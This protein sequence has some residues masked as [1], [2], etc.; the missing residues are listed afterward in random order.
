[1]QSL[2][3]EAKKAEEDP[4][5]VPQHHLTPAQMTLLIAYLTCVFAWLAHLLTDVAE[6]D[7]F[8]RRK[9]TTSDILT[10]CL[11][12]CGN[13]SETKDDLPE[14]DTSLHQ[15]RL[16]EEVVSSQINHLK[17]DIK[18]RHDQT[19]TAEDNEGSKKSR[20][21]SVTGKHVAERQ[22]PP[23]AVTLNKFMSSGTLFGLILIYFF[24]CDYAKI[25][26]QGERSYSRDTFL[27]LVF[28]FFLA[29]CAFTLKSNPDKILN[30]DQTEEWKGWM[31]VM[32]VWYH[33]FMAKE[34]YNWIRIYI[35]C[36]VWMTG[37][38]NFSFFWVRND[39]S[40]LRL[41]KMMFR[42]NFLVTFVALTT[43]NEYMLYYICAMHTYWFLS[44][45]IFMRT[46]NSWNRSSSLMAVKFLVY[47]ICNAVIFDIPGVTYYVFRPFTFILGFHDRSEDILHEWTFRAGLDHWACFF[48]MLCAYN[49]PHFEAFM[50]Y[51]DSKSMNEKDKAIKITLR[52][53]LIIG[54][55]L[56]G[57]LWYSVFMWRDKISYNMTH[58][59][60]SMIPIA[61]FIVLR[62]VHPVL[63][64]YH[65]NM[66]AWLG[67]ITLETYLSQLHIY[68]LA[69]ARTLLVFL[70]GY[71]LLNFALATITYLFVSHTL[72]T[73]TNDF[74]N[75]LI[76]NDN[77]KLL[78]NLMY[79]VI[80]FSVS[81]L[82]AYC[83]SASYT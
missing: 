38:G 58:P 24:L 68:L 64:S 3:S 49:Y 13:K 22:P 9:T 66:F 69:N 57:V 12:E 74:S 48:G 2:L 60:S 42:L 51:L 8:W 18:H 54:C 62:N 47:A 11:V 83:T 26:P 40:L 65:V 35:A 6:L 31:Q 80:V 19:G 16:S 4:H 17:E 53:L 28:I 37:F 21:P 10:N 55:T 70:V 82:F 15:P 39:F 29:G 50:K 41:L 81:G 14:Q 25:F 7:L 77:K 34:W 45:Y 79:I 73:I 56:A 44:T 78:S 20:S 63:R 52:I 76:P 33:Y 5:G 59:Y 67:K 32:F 23:A 30:R 72:F 1:M 75:F 61:I 36:Y 27:F 43:N 46:L 71:P